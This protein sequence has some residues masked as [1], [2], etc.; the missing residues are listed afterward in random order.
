MPPDLRFPGPLISLERVQYRY[1]PKQQLVL[2]GLDLIIHMG[3]RV[4]VIGLNGSGKSTLIKLVTDA[5]S[6]T[7]GL[8]ARHPRLRIGYYSQHAVEELQRYG[9][10]AS[11]AGTTALQLLSA[12][13]GDDMTEQEILRFLTSL[14]LSGRTALDV[15]IEKLSGGQLVSDTVLHV[16]LAAQFALTGRLQARLALARILWSHPH[17]LVLDEVTTHLDFYTVRAL[18]KALVEFS[19]ALLLVSHDR[20]L[21]KYVVEGEKPPDMEESEGEEEEE[22]TNAPESRRMVYIMKDRKLSVETGGVS[23]FERAL[24]KRVAKLWLGG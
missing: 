2:D 11:G 23:S 24:E 9:H 13:V 10:G 19:G 3:D 14:G 22:D 5:I 12:E 1:A 7:R 20:F 15:P 17:L 6:P 18:A 16:A 8:I 4:G 21:I